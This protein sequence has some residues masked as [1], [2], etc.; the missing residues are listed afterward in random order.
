MADIK[1]KEK[2]NIKIK[3][4]DK[5][6]VYSQNFKSNILNLK[7]K[8]EYNQ[9]IEN[10]SSIEYGAN[11]ITESSKQ[12]LRIG[13]DKFNEYGQKSAKETIENI[14]ETS[15]KIKTK[16]KDKKI[17]KKATTIK[18]NNVK[19]TLK[20]SPKTI[21]KNYT[22]S[23]KLTEK[24]IN[25]AKKAY[26]ITK[27]RAKAM[28]KSA[29]QAL[30][31]TIKAVR[32]ILLAT[33]SL[34]FFILGGSWIV[35]FIIIVICLI[36]MLVSSV[37]GIFFS[38]EDV[39]STITVNNI[40]QPITMDTL[41][42]DLNTEFTNKITQIQKENPYNEFDITGTRAEW[43]DVLAVYVA[44]VSGGDNRVEMITLDDNKVNILKEIFWTMNKISFTKEEE[45]HQET[46][47]HLT[48]TEYKTITYTKL[49][50]TIT[51]KSVDEMADN[52]NFNQEQ[53]NQLKEMCD[54][55]YS[56]MWSAVIYGNSVGNNDIVEVARSQ[57]GNIGGQPYWSW[58]GYKERVEWCACFV[59]WCAEQCGYISAG[60]IPKFASC[61]T[62]GVS[63]FKT[64]GLWKEGGYSPKSRRY[65]I[66]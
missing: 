3:K 8:A 33:K 58:Y 40:Q 38:N 46:I 57:I 6:K 50:I 42:A 18:E 27:T 55:K 37:F 43:K 64:C 36:G 61:E 16:I 59:S 25:G 7:S 52:Y 1:T 48:W 54:E 22:S 35:I 14:K 5:A 39:G 29:K 15:Q 56:S 41:I 62:E 47:F 13:I 26:Q 45:T 30:I 21:S 19:K 34:L 12:F 44:K 51:S 20:N 32:A 23:K 31:A 10:D 66:F 63:W 17:K 28:A 24:G 9:N 49:H 4:I 60:I 2:S 53:R 11:Q 65:N